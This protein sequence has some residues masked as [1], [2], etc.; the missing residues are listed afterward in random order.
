[1][2]RGSEKHRTVSLIGELLENPKRLRTVEDNDNDSIAA[3]NVVQLYLFHLDSRAVGGGRRGCGEGSL[4]MS[5]RLS[6]CWL[7]TPLMVW[8][9]HGSVAYR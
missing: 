1:M 5:V 3:D 9:G 7:L 8:P 6:V 4:S 2:G